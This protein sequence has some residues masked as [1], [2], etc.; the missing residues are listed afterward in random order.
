MNEKDV[1]RCQLIQELDPKPTKHKLLFV[2]DDPISVQD[3]PEVELSLAIQIFGAEF[4]QVSAGSIFDMEKET[5]KVTGKHQS[6][7]VDFIS[8]K[9]IATDIGEAIHRI[10]TKRFSEVMVGLGEDE[11][12][13]GTS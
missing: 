5:R 6:I 10:L 1:H 8:S 12:C 9:I 4:K 2:T 13:Q 7:V 3:L 11:V